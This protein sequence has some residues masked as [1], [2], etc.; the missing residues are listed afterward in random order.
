MSGEKRIAEFLLEI[1]MKIEFRAAR[2]HHHLASI[3]VEEERDVY[4][5]ASRFDPLTAA[6]LTFPFPDYGAVVVAGAP[7]DGR[8]HG[9]GADGEAAE[10]N[11]P[12]R[13]AANFGN[14]SVEDEA[15][16]L[17]QAEAIEEKIK[18]SA[19]SD[20]APCERTAVG[21]K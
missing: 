3:V 21:A 2:I 6:S 12:Q 11:H 5:L 13:C 18:P 7:G 20:D 8:C 16:T 4:A 17:Q 15:P 19:K 1:A 9:V 10:L 14:G